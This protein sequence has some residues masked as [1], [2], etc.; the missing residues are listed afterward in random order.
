MCALKCLRVVDV[1][2]LFKWG[3]GTFTFFWYGDD[4]LSVS[5]G[6][7]IGNRKRSIE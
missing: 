5:T 4:T 7:L 2:D 3:C 6:D 1:K